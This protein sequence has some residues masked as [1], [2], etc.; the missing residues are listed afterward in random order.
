[1]FQAHSLA[2]QKPDSCPRVN[3]ETIKQKNDALQQLVKLQDAIR[4]NFNLLKF[5]N[6][7]TEKVLS[8]T[9]KPITDPFQQL[10]NL[11]TPD[12]QIKDE[13]SKVGET[14]REVKNDGLKIQRKKESYFSLDEGLSDSQSS[15]FEAAVNGNDLVNG[16]V[17]SINKS[18]TADLDVM[19]GIRKHNNRLMMGNSPVSFETDKIIIGQSTFP[20][21][22]GLIE[23]LFKKHP[24]EYDDEDLEIYKQILLLTNAHR[25]QY[26][27]NEGIR[28]INSKKYS[29]IIR[30]LFNT[31][32][33]KGF[34]NK[35][36][37]KKV[38]QNKFT[39]SI[40]K[41]KVTSINRI[42]DYVYWDD[43]NELVDRLKL[44]VAEEQ[45]GNNNHRNEIN[46]I[47]EELKEGGYIY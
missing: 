5:Q 14:K 30:P 2:L 17:Y 22:S 12:V 42:K 45:A 23:L 46:S 16:Y 35:I 9:F 34:S 1:M 13:D 29:N 27:H 8:E 47:L 4:K 37:C 39:N 21:T 38:K 40:M 18:Q 3:M 25:R 6:K 24:S 28:A 11:N 20:K 41:Y 31:S 10:I 15:L 36:K 32:Q 33:G 19:T 43:P 44:L 7:D 26:K